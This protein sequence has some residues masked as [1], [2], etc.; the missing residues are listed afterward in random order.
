MM[1]R[2]RVL[3]VLL[4]KEARRHLAQRGGIFL[5]L[6]LVAATLLMTLFQAD[7]SA[8]TPVLGGLD[9]CYIDIWQEDAWVRHL[10][11]HVPPEL[12]KRIRFRNVIQATLPGQAI[13]YPQGAGAIQLR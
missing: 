1:V 7:G 6:L 13:T 2:W 3:R 11:E 9:K 8:A 5:A 10:R 12:K 4:V